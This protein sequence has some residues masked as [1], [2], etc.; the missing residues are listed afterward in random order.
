MTCIRFFCIAGVCGLCT[1]IFA[2]SNKPSAE[3]CVDMQEDLGWVLKLNRELGPLPLTTIGKRAS[4]CG[5]EGVS[6]SMKFLIDRNYQPTYN[7]ILY[8][9][10]CRH[11]PSIVELKFPMYVQILTLDSLKLEIQKKWYERLVPVLWSID[12]ECESKREIIESDTVMVK[13]VKTCDGLND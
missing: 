4:E 10:D 7:S 2:K 5:I 6:L 11:L 13:I 12:Y 1:S 8:C 9:N 3:Y